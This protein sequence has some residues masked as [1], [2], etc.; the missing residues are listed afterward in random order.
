MD[1][2]DLSQLFLAR[3]PTLKACPRF[4]RGSVRSA[5]DAVLRERLRAKRVADEQGTLRAW[6]A[7]ALMPLML[8]HRLA[9]QGYVS[10]EELERRVKAFAGGQWLDLLQEARGKERKWAAGPKITVPSDGHA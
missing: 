8:H 7:L 5:F 3:I 1:D 10:R 2:V 9:G 6:R 4:L